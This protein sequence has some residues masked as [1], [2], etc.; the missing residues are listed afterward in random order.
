MLGQSL[1]S[2]P[3]LAEARQMITPHE[4]ESEDSILAR[5]DPPSA[6]ILLR[7]PSRQNSLSR[8]AIGT[9]HQMLYD[10]RMESRVRA[11]IIT[12]TDPAFC[13][14]TDLTE[15]HQSQ[16]ASDALQQW[17]VD[18][19]QL[20]ELME[21]LMR[22]PK[23]LIAATNGITLGVGL[24]L[25][26]ACD[27]IIA[28]PAARFGIPEPR[29]GLTSSM[30]L[31]LLQ[32]RIGGS[33]TANLAMRGHQIDA[34]EAQSIGL[35][36]RIVPH[37]RLWACCHELAGEIAHNS[38]DALALTKRVLNETVGEPVFKQLSAAAAAMASARTTDSAIEGVS[39]F[40]QKRPPDWI[41]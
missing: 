6:T 28:S 30:A 29:R 34:D 20:C 1:P 8:H 4:S 14:G 37:D 36:Q 35:I 32:F 16:K 24:A 40:K 13:A 26:A 10:L 18:A 15:I 2:D 7:R 9:L 19:Q 39:A 33:H 27:I 5:I 25:A 21:T 12:G 41:I 11:I 23:P 38:A 3:Y 31:P 17:S 22:F